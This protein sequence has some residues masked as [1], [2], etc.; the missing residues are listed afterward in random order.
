MILKRGREGEQKFMKK[1][2]GRLIYVS[3]FME[4]KNGRLVICNEDGNIVKDARYITHPG[5]QG[6]AWW[7][8]AQLLA[9]VNKSITIFEEVHPGCVALFIFDQ[10]SAHASLT[11]DVLRAFDMNKTNGGKQR[12]QRDTVIPMN[13]PYLAFCGKEQKMTMESGDTKGLQQTL[14]ERGFSFDKKLKGKLLRSWP[15]F[16]FF[17]IFH[18]FI[19]CSWS[20]VPHL[21]PYAL[22]GPPPNHLT[23]HLMDHLTIPQSDITCHHSAVHSTL[24][25]HHLTLYGLPAH[26]GAILRTASS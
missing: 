24:Q 7:D 15:L 25:H 22:L 20:L 23:S 9:Q 14:E 8:H 13:N 6:D 4:E 21:F 18:P 1:G 3:D 12:K 2:R 10:S 5:A 17:T 26:D 11:S 19:L 16:S